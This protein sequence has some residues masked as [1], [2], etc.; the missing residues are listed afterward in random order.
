MFK[1]RLI[2][3]SSAAVLV[4]V[5]LFWYGRVGAVIFAA[6]SIGLIAVAV[7]EFNRLLE[8]FG[9]QG[10]PRVSRFFGILM[11]GV[12]VVPVSLGPVVERSHGMAG[13]YAP[14]LL[15]GLLFLATTF[16]WAM[17]RPNL[18]DSMIELP[19]AW[20]SL[21]VVYGMLGF[22]PKLYYSSGLAAEGRWVV[23]FML[24]V[25]KAGDIGAYTVGTITS[26][27]PE[28]NHKMA[29]VLSPHKSWEGFAGGVATSVCLAL[30]LIACFG[31]ALTFQGRT[32]VGPASAILLGLLFSGLGSFGDLAESAL[33]RAAGVKDSGALPGLGG[34]LD[35]TDSL[36]FVAPVFYLYLWFRTGM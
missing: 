2:S 12:I 33:K 27:R 18:R 30:L 20:A 36:L 16:V 25:T 4:F 9:R 8:R 11:V 3:G 7:G 19:F 24:A 31:G 35:M 1:Q 10:M 23:F 28:G 14:E 6:L 5:S 22:I 26:K 34:V 13:W 17:R 32:A 21:I 29:P 15:L